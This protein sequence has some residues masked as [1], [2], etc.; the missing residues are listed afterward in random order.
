MND[1]DSIIPRIPVGEWGNT[2]IVWFANTFEW[3]LDLISLIL[4]WSVT[5][6]IDGLLFVPALVLIP[7]FALIGWL[8]RSWQLAIG[9]VVSFLLVVAMDTWVPAMQTL[10]LVLIATLVAVLIAVPIGILAARN[11]S[12]SAVVKPVLDFMQTMPAFVYLLPA[13]LFFSIGLVPGLFA[14]V[15]FA[16]PPGVR[17]TELGIRGVD[18]ETVEAGQAF[19]ATPRQILRGIQLPLATPT[20]MAG[21]NQVIMLALS[22]AVIAGIAGADGLG[23]EVVQSIATL[24][25][26][27]GIEAG[28][29]VVIIAIYL[30]RVTAAL[31]RP[32]DYQHS[33][34][35]QLRRRQ[36]STRADEAK[37]SSEAPADSTA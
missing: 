36:A 35:G 13:V 12:V 21:V 18:A 37:A 3:L 14:T 2:A 30:D 22:M 27:Q 23:K 31:G 8:L 29:A 24:N 6:L 26:P 17:L 4:E 15:I 7:V 25:R 33:L 32:G 28:L 20:I 19:G 9:T 1:N 10:A 11:S 34:R 16:L 5:T